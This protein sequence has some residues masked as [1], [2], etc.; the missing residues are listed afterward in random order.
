MVYNSISVLLPLAKC[1][2]VHIAFLFFSM[3]KR[4]DHKI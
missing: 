3:K 1:D 4:I 2:K